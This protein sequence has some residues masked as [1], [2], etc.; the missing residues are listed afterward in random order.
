[1]P[2]ANRVATFRIRLFMLNIGKIVGAFSSSQPLVCR[3][4]HL[5]DWF[6]EAASKTESQLLA[7]RS[8][9]VVQGGDSL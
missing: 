5:V 2:P 7:F 4:R 1:M 8:M 3:R 9:N 6:V